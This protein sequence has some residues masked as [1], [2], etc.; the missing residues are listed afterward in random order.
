MKNRKRLLFFELALST[1]RFQDQ[2][3]NWTGGLEIKW[4]QN[5][6]V[7]IKDKN[8]VGIENPEKIWLEPRGDERGIPIEVWNGGPP[9]FPKARERPNK[10]HAWV[11]KIL[12]DIPRFSPI[13]MFQLCEEKWYTNMG[14][15]RLRQL[16][17]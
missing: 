12:E 1:K 13:I 2:I 8:F 6:W 10:D 11:K 17:R 9:G 7:K 15:E 16:S 4:L 3:Q 14:R 5:K